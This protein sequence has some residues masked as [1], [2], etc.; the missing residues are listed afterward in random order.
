MKEKLLK[1][2]NDFKTA[3]EKGDVQTLIGMYETLGIDTRKTTKLD[4]Y[5]RSLMV[6]DIKAYVEK[7]AEKKYRVVRMG[8]YHEPTYD[9]Y[10]IEDD[11]L[12]RNGTDV[13]WSSIGKLYAAYKQ[14]HKIK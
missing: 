6:D 7:R 11:K 4:D 12:L 13:K 14:I 2:I 5:L 10:R 9:T 8:V 1:T 3:V